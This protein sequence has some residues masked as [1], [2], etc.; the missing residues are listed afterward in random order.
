VGLML[1][2]GEKR[3]EMLEKATDSEGNS[4]LHWAARKGG[5]TSCHLL[6]STTSRMLA[7]QGER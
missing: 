4:V 7:A 6:A 3:D 5:S 1:D 2:L